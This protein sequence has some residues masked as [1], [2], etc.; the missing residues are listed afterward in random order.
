MFACIIKINKIFGRESWRSQ[1]NWR[2]RHIPS[3][4]AY[5][6]SS[7]RFLRSLFFCRTAIICTHPSISQVQFTG[8]W[9]IQNLEFCSK[10]RLRDSNTQDS[11]SW[12]SNSCDSSSWDSTAAEEAEARD[13]RIPDRGRHGTQDQVLRRGMKVRRHEIPDRR[14]GTRDQDRRDDRQVLAPL[15]SCKAPCSSKR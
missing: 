15:L 8:K 3:P 7:L 4:S 1:C 6:A 9:K 13:D 12:D 11:S 5:S 14:R 10:D 2:R